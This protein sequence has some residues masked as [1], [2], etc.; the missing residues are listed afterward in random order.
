M[1]FTFEV[2]TPEGARNFTAEIGSSLY[3]V[4]AN[5]GGKT[6]LSVL[7]ENT[8]GTLA[9]R[10]SAHRALVLNPDVPKLSEASALH[11]LRT[12][13]ADAASPHTNRSYT[14]WGQKEAVNL[15]NDFDFVL[16]SL[17]ANQA[18]RALISHNNARAGVSKIP[19][20]TK[21][22]SLV[23]IWD[24]VFP[25]RQIHFTGDNISVSVR[26]ADSQ[27]SAS[28]MS[29]GERAVFYLIG[30]VLLADEGSIIIFDEPELHIHRSI[31]SRL[32]DEIEAA[33]ADCAMIVISHDLDFIAGRR[34]TTFVL[35]DYHPASGWI[36][37]EVPEDAAFSE[38]LITLIL[39]SRKPILFVE[40]NGES[41]DQ[42]IYRACYPD[43]TIIARGSCQ[44]VIHS[45]T[46]MRAN[47]ILT[48]VTCAGIVDADGQG[49]EDRAY[50][51][52]KGVSILPVSEIENLLILPA[53]LDAI[54]KI[55][56]FEG[57][58]LISRRE[59]LLGELFERAVDKATL[60]GLVISYSRRKID[61][62]LKKIDLSGATDVAGLVAAYADMTA[63]LD[64]N[65][66]AAGAEARIQE[67]IEARD[68]A[69]LLKWY[70]NKSSVLQI[71]AA[72]KGTNR[73]SFEDWLVR[74]LRNETGAEIRSALIPILPVI[75]PA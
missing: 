27:Y 75:A 19:E 25:H 7:I 16:Q 40:G 23:A 29:D 52:R 44:E 69:E 72:A 61:R 45:V 71:A 12:G 63:A 22:E 74:A 5:G 42:A 47:A 26:G 36:I 32:W 31:V 33:R 28:Q 24:R 1:T 20:A 3:F 2:P 30:Q 4:G 15:L 37:D 57:E 66:I 35:R 59:Q 17:F 51:L 60:C 46:S 54:L 53:V 43:W 11:G 68:A 64:I 8:F 21:S 34:G 49:V 14:R 9:H 62:T 55:E 58:G 48:R 65:G 38:E 39:G 10:I 56:G 41:L 18:N 13:N 67:A 73:R 50:L 6:R 70:E